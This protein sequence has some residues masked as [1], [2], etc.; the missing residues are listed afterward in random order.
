MCSK[1]LLFGTTL[2]AI[3][4][5]A[6][7]TKTYESSAKC[8]IS[9]FSASSAQSVKV[10]KFAVAKVHDVLCGHD[11]HVSES[12]SLAAGD[13]ADA[14]AQ[15]IAEVSADCYAGGDAQYQVTGTSAATAVAT[16][17]AKAY[18]KA[19][20]QATTCGK[21]KIAGTVVAESFEKIFLKATAEVELS[22]SGVAAG[23]SVSDVY[24]VVSEALSE[25]TVKAFAHAIAHARA[26]D[27]RCSGGAHVYTGAGEPDDLNTAGCSIDLSASTDTIVTNAV[28]G[29][30][31]HVAAAACHSH[32]PVRAGPFELQ[33]KA[34]GKAMA[35]AIT[36]I[37]ADCQVQGVG[38]GCAISSAHITH[39]AEAVA[40]AFVDTFVS[41]ASKCSHICTTR[42][43]VLVTA[44]ASVLAT[45]ASKAM[46][47]QC[48]GADSHFTH[49]HTEKIIVEASITALAKLISQAT[50]PYP[51]RCVI[52]LEHD[53]AVILPS[54]HD[55]VPHHTKPTT[56]H[57]KPRSS[58]KAAK[59]DR[60][61]KKARHNKKMGKKARRH[62][63]KG[64]K[65]TAKNAGR[66]GHRG[67]RAGKGKKNRRNL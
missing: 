36:H 26:E 13:V 31:S 64:S 24:T 23:S 18:A 21:C 6:W 17:I 12:A 19:E 46:H 40:T 32:A 55:P 11:D 42:K 5:G 3:S 47:H 2:L 49:Y 27:D 34:V 7:A 33:A 51:G 1:S 43:H 9:S 44:M 56:G 16:A 54:A 10:A 66:S 62:D 63:R 45:A 50:V 20:V 37:S 41:A 25:T 52:G 4:G 8:K 57:K 29:V 48:T 14:F 65:N 58:S 53:V 67:N 60:S 59:K 15:A 38:F 22:L 61:N 35:V 39:T 28:A 30:S